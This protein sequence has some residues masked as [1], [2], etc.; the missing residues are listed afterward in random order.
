MSRGGQE[1]LVVAVAAAAA[2][3]AEG[4]TTMVAVVPMHKKGHRT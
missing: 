4:Y 3:T 1:Q 2:G